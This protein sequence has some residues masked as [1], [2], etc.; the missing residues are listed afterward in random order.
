MSIANPL[1]PANDPVSYFKW[2]CAHRKL[3]GI[4][5]AEAHVAATQPSYCGY[6][7]TH[8]ALLSSKVYGEDM[9]CKGQAKPKVDQ[10]DKL[11]ASI[12]K[13]SHVKRKALLARIAA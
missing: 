2:L 3:D 7:I 9:K 5:E 11:I 1:R 8:P 12:N 6:A 13:L 4:K 10:L